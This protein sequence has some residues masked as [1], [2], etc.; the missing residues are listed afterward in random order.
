MSSTPYALLNPGRVIA[1]PG[2]IEQLTE[3]AQGFFQARRVLIISD[4]GVAAA[5][6]VNA[7]PA[8]R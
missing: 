1:G 2:S 3:L 6:L 4:K 7:P 5:G 8:C